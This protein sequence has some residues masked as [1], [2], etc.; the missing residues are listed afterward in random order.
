MLKKFQNQRFLQNQKVSVLVTLLA[1][2]V[3]E[4]LLEEIGTKNI[5]QPASLIIF[6]GMRKVNI[7][8][9]SIKDELI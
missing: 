7:L 2:T 1:Q 6:Y 3:N 9:Y 4:D 5:S 8:G